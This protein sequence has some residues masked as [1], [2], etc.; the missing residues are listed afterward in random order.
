[1]IYTAHTQR[2]RLFY[3][4][5]YR[6]GRSHVDQKVLKEMKEVFIH[7]FLD[8]SIG[9]YKGEVLEI[10]CGDGLLTGYL[11]ARGLKVQAVDISA[12]GIA[13]LKRRYHLAIRSGQLVAKCD[14]IVNFLTRTQPKF[15]FIVGSGIIHHIDRQEWPLFFSALR[16]SLNEGGVL[17]CGPEP[18]ADWPYNFIWQFAQLVYETFYHTPYDQEIEKGTLDM[19]S[20]DLLGLMRLIGF[21]EAKIKPFHV[22]P[23][24]SQPWL[25]KLDQKLV[26][27]VAGRYAMYTIVE[28]RK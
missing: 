9:E 26:E 12:V 25:A 13:T 8:Q 2:Q 20:H 19:K 1:M 18:N 10:G 27:F 4:Q 15:D 14:E 23:H 22:L 21:K 6:E 16:N 24:F 17:A 7:R 11:L 28:A 3:D 5:F